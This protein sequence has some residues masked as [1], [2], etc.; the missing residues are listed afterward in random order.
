MDNPQFEKRKK[1][2][3]FTKQISR[4][5]E[6]KIKARKTRKQGLWFGLGMFGMVGWSVAIPTVIFIAIGIYIDSR[7]P[8]RISWT[9]IFLCAGVALGCLN[10]WYWVKKESSDARS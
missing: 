4:K 9:L 2:E 5:K 3:E 1:R 6:R 8:G 10:A 7:W